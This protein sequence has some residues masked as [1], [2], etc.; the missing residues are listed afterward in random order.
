MK[1]TK[2]STPVTAVPREEALEL[3]ALFNARRYAELE[4]RAQLLVMRYPTSGFVWK[5][6]GTALLVQGKDALQ[7]LQKAVALSPADVE[8]RNNLGN[9]LRAAG[10]FDEAVASYRCAL[11]IKPDDCAAHYNLGLALR[12]VGRLGESVASYR[13]AL[14]INPGFADGHYNLGISLKELGHLED[15]VTSYRRALAIKPD[16]VGALINL[17]IA[18][19]DLGRFDEAVESTRRVLAIQP[20]LADAHSN[21]GNL[22]KDL[23]QL[24]AAVASFN[25]ALAIKPDY[26]EAHSNL[27]FTLN[28]VLDQPTDALLREAR[29]Y[30][31]MVGKKAAPYADWPN[32]PEPDRALRVGLVSGDFSQHPVGFFVEGV[33]A[34]LA[35]K[36]SDGLAIFAYSAHSQSDALTDRIKGSC[37][38]WCAAA[39]VSDADLAERIRQDQIDILI[40]LSGHTAYNRLPMFAL[41]PAPVQVTWLGYFATTGVAAIDYLIADPWTLPDAAQGQFTEQIWRLPETRLC[42]TPPDVAVQVSPLPA[43]INQHIT[44]GCFNNITKMNDAVVAVWARVLMAVP[45]SRLFLKAK[46]LDEGSVRQG[47]VARFAAKGISEDRLILEGK[48]DRATY[49]AAYN[50][51]DI[52]LDPFPFTGGTT[53]VESLWMGVPVVTLAGARLV[54]RQ[55]VGLMMNAG[56]PDWVASDTDDYV[57][58]AASHAQDVAGLAALRGRLRQQVLASPVFDAPRFAQFFEQALRGMWTRWCASAPLQNP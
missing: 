11:D 57:A 35:N 48:S 54:S 23:G 24:D 16:F 34:A 37:Q 45:G 28:Y 30:G 38:G 50:K 5:I 15:A 39:G 14:T 22:L 41:R 2:S 18:L 10:R 27:L 17:G 25:K 46:Q 7:P 32:T 12:D 40:D 26:P 1:K 19:K 3:V 9:A 31:E 29:S 53:S 55:G 51:V 21:L 44:F 13:H 56:L 20:D 33:I 6:F 58:R 42:F 36:A 52:G 8:S 43:L 47:V 49:L 4:A